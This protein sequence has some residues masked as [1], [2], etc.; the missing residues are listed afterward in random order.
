MFTYWVECSFTHSLIYV[1]IVSISSV[2]NK[3]GGTR[4]S[5]A[6]VAAL[7][8]PQPPSATKSISISRHSST[9]SSPTSKPAKSHV[10]RKNAAA[11]GSTLLESDDDSSSLVKR[12]QIELSQIILELNKAKVVNDKDAGYLLQLEKRKENGIMQCYETLL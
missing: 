2:A 10:K 5:A 1:L 9:A 7:L 6:A 8:P 4:T 12:E 3:T 11:S